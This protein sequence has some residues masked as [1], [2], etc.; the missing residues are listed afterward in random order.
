MSVKSR[1]ST[2]IK[3]VL[4]VFSASSYNL[5]Q[6]MVNHHCEKKWCG[7]HPGLTPIL[8]GIESDN[9]AFNNTLEIFIKKINFKAPG[10]GISDEVLKNYPRK[11][12]KIFHIV[13]KNLGGEK[14][15]K[16]KI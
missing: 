2:S 11:I 16:I 9:S 13:S 4:K 1:L 5:S 6:H 14:G 10:I 8:T 3:T 15:A 7:M 12:L